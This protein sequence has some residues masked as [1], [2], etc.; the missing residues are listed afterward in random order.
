MKRIII[1]LTTTYISAQDNRDSLLELL[2][3]LDHTLTTHSHTAVKGSM[4][5]RRS[6]PSK[7]NNDPCEASGS[8]DA[9][10]GD[11]YDRRWNMLTTYF[12]LHVELVKGD[13]NLIMTEFDAETQMNLNLN[14]LD[15]G[16]SILAGNPGTMAKPSKR[17]GVI[18]ESI[19]LTNASSQLQAASIAAIDSLYESVINMTQSSI[20]GT[21]ELKSNIAAAYASL[22]KQ[23][24]STAQT[25]SYSAGNSTAKMLT[26]GNSAFSSS[27]N[28]ASNMQN[29]FQRNVDSASARQSAVSNSITTGTTKV[30][31]GL[32]DAR[33]P[34]A[35][36]EEN[37]EQSVDNAANAF[38][39][40]VGT[41]SDSIAKSGDEKAGQVESSGTKYNEAFAGQT[42]DAAS[43]ATNEWKSATDSEAS[44][45]E[46]VTDSLNGKISTSMTTVQANMNNVSSE[47]TNSINNGTNRVKTLANDVTAATKDMSGG[48]TSLSGTVN[49]Q[50]GQVGTTTTS[51]ES[52]AQT[53]AS[54]SKK[55]IADMITELAKKSGQS[56]QS[57]IQALNAAQGDAQTQALG[58]QGRSQQSMA[59]FLDQLGNDNGKLANAMND[60]TQMISTSESATT[61]ELEGSFNGV[62]G[63]A[64]SAQSSLGS[65]MDS[66]GNALNQA[67]SGFSS[68]ANAVGASFGKTL[69]SGSVTT[70]N[71]VSGFASSS[72][73]TKKKLLD[74]MLSSSSAMTETADDFSQSL[75]DLTGGMDSFGQQTKDANAALGATANGMDNSVA[76]L[77]NGMA[78]SDD[79]VANAI[80]A[81][82]R[83]SGL[84]LNSFGKEFMGK[85][86]SDMKKLWAKIAGIL[87]QKEKENDKVMNGA[88]QSEILALSKYGNL[89]MMGNG[90]RA[91]LEELMSNSGNKAQ[92]SHDDF[93][94]KISLMQGKDNSA[95]AELAA[96]LNQ[97]KGD[98][99]GDVSS[100]LTQLLNGR[101]NY[102]SNQF[103]SQRSQIDGLGNQ[104]I[105]ATAQGKKLNNVIADILKTSSESRG[106]VA[107]RVMAIL[108]LTQSQAGNFENRIN[109]VIEQLYGIKK[110]SR[111]GLQELSTTIQQE[112]LKIPSIITSGAVRLQNDFDL[113]SSDLDDNIVK[114]KEKLATAQSEE[115][116]EEAKKGLVV[117][118]KMKAIQEGV[119]EADSKLRKQI[120]DNAYNGMISSENVDGAMTAVLGAMT[121][122]NSE[123]DTKH[124]A[125]QSDTETI[126]KQTATLVNGMNMLISSTSDN[127]AQQAANAAVESRFNLNLAEARNKVRAASAIN[128]VSSSLDKF[129]EEHKNAFTDETGVRTD[130]NTM[131]STTKSAGV[132]L[133]ERI[134]GVLGQVLESAEKLRQNSVAGEG[135]VL[136]RLAL[137]RMAMSQFLGLWNEYVQTMDRKFTR[138]NSN[139]DEFISQMNAD[140]RSRLISAERSFNNSQAEVLS[141]KQNVEAAIRSQDD[142]ELTFSSHTADI[143]S[144]LKD[145]NALQEQ[146]NQE[147]SQKLNELIAFEAKTDSETKESIKRM[148]DQFD[149]AMSNRVNQASVK[150]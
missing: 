106:G 33:D 118:N 13:S 132:S 30:S 43:K 35:E 126:G 82:A 141:L 14:Q 107:D 116:R 55:K 65:Q 86:G 129:D 16:I 9:T 10:N 111:L 49:T 150:A 97:Y 124:A 113:A 41:A 87:A 46:N 96:L 140:L 24:K 25:Q 127:L 147:S 2:S 148:L 137:V 100:Q 80:A 47:A 71:A 99:F 39:D 58:A 31:Q 95:T 136:T 108:G 149:S 68:T 11:C 29:G 84:D 112:V 83:A 28:A 73:S 90:M 19:L 138:F 121:A 12:P 66:A 117:L 4:D 17:D 42:S 104:V 67:A 131:T 22:M 50:A 54:E 78:N 130:I 32:S 89:A 69:N 93:L 6:W 52:S 21:K 109:K 36:L 1:F 114:L 144:D 110:Q 48:I 70:A 134:N 51:V 75:D 133:N 72:A 105:D 45:T 61:K 94:S 7:N 26:Q 18:H 8:S 143:K 102:F 44:K 40:K 139:D 74:S 81:A 64:R 23:V 92:L 145:M 79:Q 103:N 56:V 128:S 60:L 125:I 57:I 115:E 77:A 76:A 123:M 91:A 122:L 135:D 27:V 146:K 85:S 38:A 142:Y 98:A 62:D 5:R 63:T 15:R 37:V 119:S 120:Q 3:G 20:D 88:E 101:S 53:S 59:M 34:I